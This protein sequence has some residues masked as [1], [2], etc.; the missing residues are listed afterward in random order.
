MPSVVNPV[1]VSRIPQRLGK[2]LKLYKTQGDGN[3]L[4]RAI[5]YSITGRQV[6]HHIA[7]NKIV[8]HMIAIE[9]ALKP[10]IN[11]SLDDYLAHSGMKM[12]NVWGTDIEILTA[13][14][15]LQTDI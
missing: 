13:S 2:P 15:L 7:R 12:Q 5:S 6:Y 14:S 1:N 8:E 4:F 9:S 11:S 10:H 3:C